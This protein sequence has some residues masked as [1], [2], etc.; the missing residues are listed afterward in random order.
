MPAHVRRLSFA[1][2]CLAIALGT[3]LPGQ[4]TPSQKD[5]EEGGKPRLSLR[6]RP[7]IA[8]TPARVM[9]TA[10]L[11]GG[12]NDFEEL[13]CP[14]V[15]WEWGDETTSES[16]FDCEPYEAGKSELRRRFTAEHTF[17]RSG[18]Y[19]V[20]IHLKRRDKSVASAS[21][22]LQIRPGPREFAY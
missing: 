1:A 17:R 14:T 7:S 22:T 21:V 6:A 16:T 10:E 5:S 13:Y 8:A 12:P 11:T 3:V 2:A 9:F 4:Q 19:K 15:E 20:Y 18:S